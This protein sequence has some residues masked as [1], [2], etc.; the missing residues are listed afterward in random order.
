MS[1]NSCP[2]ARS[3]KL[4]VFEADILH[5]R[6]V[7]RVPAGQ[8]KFSKGSSVKLVRS[9]ESRHFRQATCAAS[10]EREAVYLASIFTRK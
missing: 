8:S 5:R 6:D 1:A 9:Y 2:N 10:K 7:S 3:G 4:I